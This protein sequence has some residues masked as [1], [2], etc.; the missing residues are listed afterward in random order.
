MTP[1]RY[2]FEQHETMGSAFRVVSIVCVF[3]H[4]ILQ[5]IISPLPHIRR[6]GFQEILRTPKK[7]FHQIKLKI[8]NRLRGKKNQQQSEVDCTKFKTQLS[9]L[10]SKT[11]DSIFYQTIVLFF[12]QAK[13]FGMFLVFLQVFFLFLNLFSSPLRYALAIECCLFCFHGLRVKDTAKINVI[14]LFI[15]STL[16]PIHS[17]SSPPISN[18]T[19]HLSYKQ[20]VFVCGG[21]R[22]QHPGSV[23]TPTPTMATAP[24]P[25]SDPLDQNAVSP[26]SSPPPLIS[27][28]SIS[29]I[30][31][32][33]RA[34]CAPLASTLDIG[35]SIVPLVCVFS[36]PRK[37]S[38]R[39]N[40][41]HS[42]PLWLIF[43]VKGF[44]SMKRSDSE[45]LM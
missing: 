41:N 18:L 37:S 30:F 27:I 44:M 6:T 11:L 16:S 29:L 38:Q 1:L 25:T 8:E 28:N 43:L 34:G 19:S 33:I 3:P 32:V 13:H 24:L 12:L 36:E 26:W 39:S 35:L 5:T 21:F 4:Q 45:P 9:A 2:K 17:V 42:A 10:V 14:G 31:F 20:L 7:L 15:T 23:C 22:K 40:P